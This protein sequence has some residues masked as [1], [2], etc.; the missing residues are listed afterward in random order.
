[1]RPFQAD[2]ERSF[3]LIGTIRRAHTAACAVL[4]GTA[5]LAGSAPARAA[6]CEPPGGFPSFVM[7]FK[8]QAA[9]QGISG[10]ALA[11]LDGL[12]PDPQVIALDRRQGYFR[13]S[14]EQFA[15]SRITAGRLSRGA[16]LLQQHAGLL[17]R[18]EQQYGVPGP[19]LV[20]IWGME[21]DFGANMGK[22]N[23]LRAL[24]SLAHDCRRT[25]MFQ[26][27][28]LAALRIIDR[29]DLSPA[30]MRGAWAG[31]LGQTQ[32][33]PSSYLKFAVDFDG[34]GR[35]DLIRSVPDVLASTANYLR[36]YGWQRGQPW[37]EGTPNFNALK[38]WNKA[39]VYA[40]TLALYAE[41]LKSGG[42]AVARNRDERPPR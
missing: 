30:E 24:V 32:F 37:H 12:S 19:M 29:G 7:E 16:R 13:K 15:A 4:A 20:A 26:G 11:T 33:L 39:Q 35:R 6:Q 8:R 41:K 21:T 31:E 38:G 5:L 23:A 9:A 27:E 40:K 2:E 34:N 3:P 18:I 25:E 42:A 17:A 1:M 22:S 10:R 14:F 28:L 36:G